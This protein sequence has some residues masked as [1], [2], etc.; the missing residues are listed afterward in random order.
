[1][2]AHAATSFAQRFRSSKRVSTTLAAFV[3]CA[4][5]TAAFFYRS[6]Q[7]APPLLVE[8]FSYTAAT[9]L[10]AN[11]WAA[12]SAGGTNPITVVTPG[13]TYA[14]YPSSGVGNAVSMTTSGEDDNKTFA[15]QTSGIIYA[16]FMVNVSAANLPGDYFFHLAE[17]PLTGNIFRGK[18]FVKKDASNNL[19]FGIA[20]AAN[21][22]GSI[23]FTGFTLPS[24][25]PICWWL[26]TQS[27]RARPMIRST[28]L[29]I[30]LLGGLSQH[31]P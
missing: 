25:Q 16:A 21:S 5:L 17:T 3:V 9:A 23:G 2:K 15:S 29:L 24:T 4:T 10:T 18:V 22:G 1:M 8:D 20:K 11:G 19:A 26:S 28:F 31:L 12:H 6:A 14:G 13:L 27:S 30:R 7:A